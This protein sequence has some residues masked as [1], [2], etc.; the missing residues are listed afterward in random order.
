MAK[1]TIDLD[2]EASDSFTGGTNPRIMARGKVGLLSS[3]PLDPDLVAAFEDGAS[4]TTVELD[5]TNSPKYDRANI[6]VRKGTLQH[7]K[8]CKV[9]AT[10]GGLVTLDA[11]KNETNV[12]V[13]SLVG[14]VPDF[15]ANN[16]R[17]GV[18]LDSYKLNSARKN[19]LISLGH[20]DNKIYLLTN[21]NSQM[22]TKEQDAWK[23]PGTFKNHK[24]VAQMAITIRP[25][26]TWI[27]RA[28]RRR[29]QQLR[30]PSLSATIRSSKP[31]G[32]T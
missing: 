4:I 16:L 18:S 26:S 9:I 25:N 1:I 24:R 28:P 3:I 2:S 6:K 14:G 19:Y 12:P 21:K 23:P 5:P 22:H 8:N 31:V 29:S 7:G 11:I 15:F 32:R 10:A 20:A 17:G 27:L 13:V 30:L